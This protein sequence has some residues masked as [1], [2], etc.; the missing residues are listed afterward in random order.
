MDS[1]DAIIILAKVMLCWW[2]ERQ[3]SGNGTG[4]ICNETYMQAEDKQA[5][6][7]LRNVICKKFGLIQINTT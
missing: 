6:D 2:L 7:H 3:R 4:V 1:G 5:E